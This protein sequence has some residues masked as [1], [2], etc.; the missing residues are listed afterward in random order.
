MSSESFLNVVMDDFINRSSVIAENKDIRDAKSGMLYKNMEHE[1]NVRDE[2]E[3]SSTGRP[4]VV[5]SYRNPDVKSPVPD[6]DF[7]FLPN[8]VDSYRKQDIVNKPT[9]SAD[10]APR[11]HHA[12]GQMTKLGGAGGE[13][14]KAK[15]AEPSD[16]GLLSKLTSKVKEYKDDIADHPY[17]SGGVGLGALATGLAAKKFMGNKK[18]S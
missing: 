14:A 9:A 11:E 5:D 7:Q 15:S 10:S 8:V 18:K 12:D 3:K 16:I 17:V 2:I 6:Q 13:V 1:R 4:N